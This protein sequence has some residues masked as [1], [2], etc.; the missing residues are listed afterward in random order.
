MSRRPSLDPPV[1]LR[2]MLPESIR[3]KVDL[4]LFSELEGRVPKG[5]Y[6][7]FFLE[8]IAEY[9]SNRPLDLTAYGIAGMVS[10]PKEIIEQLEWRLKNGNSL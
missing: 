10:G 1:A 6:Q 7:E 8:R 3:A 5:R 9:F 4:I 2:L